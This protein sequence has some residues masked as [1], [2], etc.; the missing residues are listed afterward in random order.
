MTGWHPG[1]AAAGQ[2]ERWLRPDQVAERLQCSPQWVTELCRSRRLRGAIKL[3]ERRWKIP[4][5]ALP[6]YVANINAE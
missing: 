1:V 6:E 3:G 4:E 5:S 2:Q